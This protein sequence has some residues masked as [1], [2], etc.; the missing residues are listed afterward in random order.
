MATK[1][2]VAVG[3]FPV[4]LLACQVSM[5]CAAN[6]PT[7]HEILI[8]RFFIASVNIRKCETFSLRINLAMR[9]GP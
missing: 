4:E 1:V 8:L 6:W 9:K 5:I 7:Q 2:F 3:V